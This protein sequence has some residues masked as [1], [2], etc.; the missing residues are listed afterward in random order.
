MG[1]AL[2]F[3]TKW[4]KEK[5]LYRSKLVLVDATGDSM[6]PRIYSGD[7]LLVNTG[8]HNDFE[9][10]KI[11]AIRYGDK[12]RVKRL[13]HRIDG[14]WIIRSDNPDKQQYPDEVIPPESFEHIDVLGR[15]VWAAGSL[16]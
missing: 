10:G 4:I 14:A 2:P 9:D 6:A 7:I 15:V 8:I 3:A 11:Y 16:D 5:G 1:P 13:Y 12:L